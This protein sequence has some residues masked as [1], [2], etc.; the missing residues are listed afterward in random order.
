MI[1][2][3]TPQSTEQS[4]LSIAD[5]T[6]SCTRKIQFCAGHRVMGHENKCAHLHGHNYE[7]HLT[8]RA[9]SLDGIGRVID[10]SVLKNVV[11]GWVENEW[12]HGFLLFKDDLEAIK[13]IEGFMDGRQKLYV[14]PVNPTA[15]NIATYL[16]NMGNQLLAEHYVQLT[17]VTVWE[18]ANCYATARADQ[19]VTL[20]SKSED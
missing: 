16:M 20:V 13:A 9:S 4:G 10:F 12:D 2:Q 15:E 7:I 17:E 1:E 6:V 5:T 14:M 8:A 19:A 11:G 18:T 3:I